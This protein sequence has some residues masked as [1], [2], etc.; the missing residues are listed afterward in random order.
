[1]EVLYVRCRVIDSGIQFPV[2]DKA[3][4]TLMPT[5]KILGVI[6]DASLSSPNQNVARLGFFHL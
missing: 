4:L 1:M 3:L 5:M 6:L 2:L